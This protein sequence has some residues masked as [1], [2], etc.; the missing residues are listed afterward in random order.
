[1]MST[2][3]GDTGKKQDSYIWRTTGDGKVR[4]LHAERDG[5]TFSWDH[6]PEGGHPGE[7]YNC[8]CRAEERDCTNEKFKVNKIRKK[9]DDVSAKVSQLKTLI[10][11]KKLKIRTGEAILK[12]WEDRGLIGV[13]ASGLS[14]SS[15]LIIKGI[16]IAGELAGAPSGMEIIATWEQLKKDKAELRDFEEELRPLENEMKNLEAELKYAEEKLEQCQAGP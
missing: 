6:P 14:R 12:D 13:I 1:M 10:H 3:Q 4:S 5:K 7:A 16:G 2:T 8:R 9:R 15:K 11:N